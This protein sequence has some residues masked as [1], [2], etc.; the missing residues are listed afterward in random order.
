MSLFLLTMQIRALLLT[1]FRTLPGQILNT[2][3]NI[4]FRLFGCKQ[5]F[6]PDLFLYFTGLFYACFAHLQCI[7]SYI[8]NS[9]S[10]LLK[11]LKR[12]FG[13]E[14]SPPRPTFETQFRIKPSQDP[15]INTLFIQILFFILRI[16]LSCFTDLQ[17]PQTHPVD[18]ITNQSSKSLNKVI[19]T[20]LGP[21][22]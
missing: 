18:H 21:L 17:Y 2:S 20:I 14:S 6:P 22:P 3:E 12:H 4:I 10:K 9:S 13:I 1:F 16:I 19:Q 5:Q 7:Q 15:F 11:S 8:N